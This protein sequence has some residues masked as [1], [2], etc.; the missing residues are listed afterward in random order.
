MIVNDEG[1]HIATSQ[2]HTVDIFRRIDLFSTVTKTDC[3]I[4]AGQIFHLILTPVTIFRLW[5][6][7][8]GGMV[9]KINFV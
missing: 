1:L 3:H 9:F 6:Q 8:G 7:T 4:R 2:R 5:D